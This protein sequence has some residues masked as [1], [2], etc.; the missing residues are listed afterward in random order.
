MGGQ[1]WPQV[2]DLSGNAVGKDARERQYRIPTSTSLATM[3][4]SA[5]VMSSLEEEEA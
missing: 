4:P 3:R 2:V 5:H 1:A